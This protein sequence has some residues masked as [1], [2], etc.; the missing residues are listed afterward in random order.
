M[1]GDA[2][3]LIWVL[4]ALIVGGVLG[5]FLATLLGSD[6]KRA[7]ALETELEELKA[8]QDSYRKEVNAHF[9]E[10]ATL[11]QGM[12]DQ[13]R[14]VYDHLARGAQSLCSDHPTPPALDLPEAR[15]LTET[16]DAPRTPGAMDSAT[17][18]ENST[19][20]TPDAAT[21]SASDRDDEE[22]ML[23]DAPHVPDLETHRPRN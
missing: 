11:F 17:Q 14:A 16:D 2:A 22:Q 3:L 18:P 20:E 9:Q 7:Q 12:T 5:Y 10:T 19:D 8:Q 1:N 21:A 4:G 13:Y 23:G 15:R 6:N